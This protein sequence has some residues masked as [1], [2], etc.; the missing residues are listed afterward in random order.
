MARYDVTHACGHVATYNLIG[1]RRTREW[2][3]KRLQGELCPDCW[4]EERKRRN[5][6]AAEEN[7]RMELPPLQGTEARVLWAES[8]RLEQIRDLEAELE[9]WLQD[10]VLDEQEKQELQ[11]ALEYIFGQT[12]ASWWIDRRTHG[13]ARLL[14]DA[15]QVLRRKR[16]TPAGSQAT[17]EAAR[18]KAEATVRPEAPKTETVAEIRTSGS[19]IEVVFPEKR[20]DFRELIRF[21]LGFKWSGTSWMRQIGQFNGDIA[22]RVAEVGHRLLA[23]GFPIRIYDPELRQRAIEGQ[24]EPEPRRWIKRATSGPYTG[25]FQIVWP[26]EDNL[27]GAARRLP[28]S[29]YYQ[30]AVYVP[31]EQ[32]QQVLD[33]AEVHGFRLS[34]GAQELAEEARRV[35]ESALVAPVTP[36]KATKRKPDE[37]GTKPPRLEVP[38]EV[39][40]DDELR[41]D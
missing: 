5:L 16:A 1:P 38:A 34:Q 23:A 37:T 7:R 20:E 18:A 6:A 41:D 14:R 40:V 33:F 11:E 36:T 28:G 9:R 17:E 21:K 39:N 29:R 13:P 12:S 19:T 22:D 30:G 3:L 8:I 32:Y 24:F 2:S 31:A 4:K 35:R 26:R 10:N 25:W 27:Y 15:V